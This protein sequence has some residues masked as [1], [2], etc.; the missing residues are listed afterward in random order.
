MKW[1]H[2]GKFG[3]HPEHNHT[4]RQATVVQTCVCDDEYC[5]CPADNAILFRDSV[6][7]EKFRCPG[8]QVRS[9]EIQVKTEVSV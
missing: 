2:C 3:D 6:R 4:A 9:T 8:K 5:T 7:R 1:Q